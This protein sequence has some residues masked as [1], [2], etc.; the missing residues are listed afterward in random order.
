M[1]RFLSKSIVALL[2]A[3]AVYAFISEIMGVTI[4]FPFNIVERQEIPYHRLLSL[5]YS[6]FLTF[7]Y[8]AIRFIFFQSEK[9]YPIQFLD[10]YIKSL[11]ISGIFVFYSLNVE[12][13]ASFGSLS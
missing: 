13:R 11:T 8:F 1:A 12:F 6:I 4:Y 9:L 7:I 5:R 10:V 2:A 3:W